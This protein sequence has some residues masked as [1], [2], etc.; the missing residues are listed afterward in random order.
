MSSDKGQ[1]Q[2]YIGMLNRHSLR[3]RALILLTL[4]VLLAVCWNLLLFEP[5][6][7]VRKNIDE[8][9]GQLQGEITQLHVEEQVIRQQAA[10]DPDHENRQKIFQM[11]EMIS[12]FDRKL[13]IQ[14]VD[15]LTP[16]E[17]PVLLQQILKRQ[18]G[19]RLIA[20][21][22]LRPGAL[23]PMDEEKKTVPGLYRH[24]LSMEL[25]G[26]YLKL[27]TYLEAL[28]KMPQ[29]VFWDILT[30]DAKQSPVIRIHLQLH[31]LSLTEDW[32]GV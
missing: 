10:V 22:N 27:L 23:L 15:L 29:R 26:S 16:Q 21:E 8:K 17:M 20:M 25:E 5:Y 7:A 31:T 4:L 2:L 24:A 14:M 19:L 30:I 9:I 12:A 32:I 18:K 1:L 28:E 11:Q 13:E 3:E 6:L